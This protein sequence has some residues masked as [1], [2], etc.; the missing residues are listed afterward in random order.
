MSVATAADRRV[1]AVYG[2][3]WD[4][5]KAR[6]LN[7]S[8][9]PYADSGVAG[10]ILTAARLVGP[11]QQAGLTVQASAVFLLGLDRAVT[12]WV[13]RQHPG[14]TT[15]TFLM[16]DETL[17]RYHAGLVNPGPPL[18]AVRHALGDDPPDANPPLVSS[19]MGYARAGAAAIRALQE[20]DEVPPDRAAPVRLS[21]LDVAL[22]RPTDPTLLPWRTAV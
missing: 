3:L 12:G 9:P 4:L 11:T 22:P 19:P 10:D 2:P 7:L 20:L 5:Y 8:R 18:E 6:V 13:R 14:V 15:D 21:W 16:Q 17:A 1:G